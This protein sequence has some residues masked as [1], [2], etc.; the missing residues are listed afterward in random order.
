MGRVKNGQGTC[1]SNDMDKA[2][3]TFFME[4][5]RMEYR[6]C[7]LQVTQDDNARYDTD[8]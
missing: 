8:F 7:A 6:S 3:A 5:N 1:S 4:S 2:I